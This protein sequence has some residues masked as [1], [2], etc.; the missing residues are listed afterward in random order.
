MS[1]NEN[2]EIY[3]NMPLYELIEKCKVD[4]KL[5]IDELIRRNEKTVYATLYHLDPDRADI[6]DLAQEVLFRMARAIK[7]LKNP[8]TFKFWL[9]QIITN[10]FYDELRKKSRRISAISMDAPSFES[11]NTTGMPTKDIPDIARIP[12]EDV[13]G[14][15]L[16]TKIR[17]SIKNLPEQ[18]KIV[19]VLRELQGLSYEEISR[20]TNTNIGTVK[21]RLARARAKLQD[22]IRPYLQ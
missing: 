6:A 18:F 16:D 3:Q 1:N 14:S 21:S 2:K 19:I 4:N 10:L 20:L 15:E 13:L 22:E 7:N 9:N 11:D 17:Q 5:A 12:E 8:A